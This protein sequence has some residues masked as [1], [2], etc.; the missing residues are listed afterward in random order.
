MPK[1]RISTEELLKRLKENRLREDL[2]IEPYFVAFRATQEEIEVRETEDAQEAALGCNEFERFAERL[3]R[4][5][6]EGVRFER[7]L[8]R[9]GFFRRIP[10]DGSLRTD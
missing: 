4:L 8:V 2:L 3:A 9:E 7:Y 1:I 6:R 10:Q 5:G